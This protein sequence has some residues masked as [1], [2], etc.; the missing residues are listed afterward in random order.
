MK[1]LFYTEFGEILDLATYLGIVCKHEVLF[2]VKEKGYKTIGEGIVEHIDEPMFYLGKD[3]V[4]VFDSCSFGE[5]QDWLREQGEAVFGGCKAGDELENDR[6]FG[7]AWF[8]EAGFKQVPSK[9]FTDL[10]AAIK[11][12]EENIGTKYI[13]KQNGDAPKSLSCATK[14][15]D[16]SDMLYHLNELKRGWN[17]ALYGKFD[18]DLMEIVEGTEVAASGFFNGTQ[19]LETE[20]GKV[21]GYLNFEEKKESDG[22]LGETC[23]EMGTTFLGC[24]ERNWLFRKILLRPAITDKLVEIGFRGVFDINCILTDAGD[25]VALEP[26]MRFGVPA[27]SYEF[28]EGMTSDV[29]ELI[30]AV[31]RGLNKSISIYQ[32]IGMVMCVV[33]KPFPLDVDVEE[34]GT[35]LGAKL[36]V[37]GKDGNPIDDFTATQRGHIHLYNFMLRAEESGSPSYKVATKGGYLLTVTRKGTNI[38]SVRNQLIEYIKSNI[39]LRGMKYRSDVGKR[40]EDFMDE[41]M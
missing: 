34:Q 13:L 9:N 25:I 7:Q 15:D 39:F 16:S 26:T 20:A 1:F 19:F 29:A 6:Q 31:A 28:I 38:K 37:L 14:F 36:W 3:Y 8:K 5:L 41:V 21:V 11:F 30:D 10:D 4:W 32:G 40:V 27:T 23:G 24:D 35:S 33:A 17:E 12:V 22:G 2:Y 18:C